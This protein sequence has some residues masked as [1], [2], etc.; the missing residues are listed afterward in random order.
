MRYGFCTEFAAA[1]KTKVD[2]SLIDRVS[3]A[4]YDFIEFRLSL[5]AGLDDAAFERFAGY[6]GGSGLKCDVCCGLFDRSVKLVGPERDDG[7][8]R[9]YLERALARADR[10]GANKLVFGSAPSRSLPKGVGWREGYAQLADMLSGILLP[11]CEKY[12]MRVA[13]EP[14]RRDACNF[15][16]TLTDGMTLVNTVDSPRVK[17]LAD[18]LHMLTNAEPPEQ[19]R[20]YSDNLLHVHI[21]DAAR[22]LPEDGYGAALDGI[23]AELSAAGYDGTISFEANG[24]AFPDSPAK[25]LKLLKKRL[26]NK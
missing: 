4:G 22:A 21:A 25:A 15:I 24:G 9:E 19:I 16:N 18:S 10:L 23:L 2:Y 1:D 11:L 3:A 26:E 14:L 17:L 8:T 5:L 20:I 13:V 6:V 7:A 12:D